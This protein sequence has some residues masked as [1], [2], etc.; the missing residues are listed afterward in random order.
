MVNLKDTEFTWKCSSQG[1]AYL[2]LIWPYLQKSSLLSEVPLVLPNGTWRFYHHQC[3]LDHKETLVTIWERLVSALIQF[4]QMR[5]T[6]YRDLRLGKLHE[7]RGYLSRLFL[8]YE[9]WVILPLWLFH[10]IVFQGLHHRQ[11]RLKS[12]CIRKGK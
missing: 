11:L 2:V 6:T 1:R 12:Y 8:P 10:C 9:Y 3:F 4:T 7:I 5:A